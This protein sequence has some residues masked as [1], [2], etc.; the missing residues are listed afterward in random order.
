MSVTGLEQLEAIGKLAR[1]NDELRVQLDAAEARV[2]ELEG[3]LQDSW[4]IEPRKLLEYVVHM[5]SN[6]SSDESG[7]DRM[8][9]EQQAEDWGPNEFVTHLADFAT[10]WPGPKAYLSKREGGA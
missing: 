3:E 2:A 4:K 6:M 1:E 8:C 9:F 5:A 10:R 7:G